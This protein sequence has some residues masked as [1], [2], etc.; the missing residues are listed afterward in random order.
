MITPR[1]HSCAYFLLE[2]PPIICCFNLPPILFYILGIF[3]QK[4]ISL[5]LLLLVLP[6]SPTLFFWFFPLCSDPKFKI[7]QTTPFPPSLL[8]L[9]LLFYFFPFFLLNFLEQ[10]S[11]PA[12]FTLLPSYSAPPVPWLWHFLPNVTLL[13]VTNKP[14]LATSW[15]FFESFILL[16]FLAI[17]HTVL[18]PS[19]KMS[20]HTASVA[21][22]SRSPSFLTTPLHLSGSSP[23]S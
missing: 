13:K 23:I 7:K 11:V 20:V 4:F 15:G 1:P 12:T 19:L 17:F 3:F 9:K 18:T 14:L 2:W 5:S 22:L 21:L 10:L 16:H 6:P 8:Q